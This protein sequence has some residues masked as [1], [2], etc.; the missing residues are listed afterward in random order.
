MDVDN[1]IVVTR[2]PRVPRLF[3]KSVEVGE[4]LLIRCQFCFFPLGY[5]NLSPCVDMELGRRPVA[6][7]VFVVISVISLYQ[8]ILALKL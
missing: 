8:K 6:D 5:T 3:S 1:L 2:R 7:G 4:N